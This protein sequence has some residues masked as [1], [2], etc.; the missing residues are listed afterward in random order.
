[1]LNVV[2]DMF[3]PR[4]A[5]TLAAQELEQARLAL[6]EAQSARE[7]AEAMCAYHQARINRLR[8]VACSGSSPNTKPY[9]GA[10]APAPDQ[11]PPD[12]RGRLD[13]FN[14]PSSVPHGY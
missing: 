13:N 11:Q 10:R 14:L 7:Y 8:A 4:A 9:V 6:L 5:E 3:R 2:R 1:M 12:S